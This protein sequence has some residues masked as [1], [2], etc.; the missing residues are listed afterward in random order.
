LDS[1]PNLS[2]AEILERE[3]LT[4]EQIFGVRDILAKIKRQMKLFF[5]YCRIKH[6]FTHRMITLGLNTPILESTNP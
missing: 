2:L 1:L 3:D 5:D 4:L 6:A